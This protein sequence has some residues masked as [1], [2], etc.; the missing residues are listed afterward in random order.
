MG[1]TFLLQLN[2]WNGEEQYQKT[3]W[4]ERPDY[5]GHIYA[6]RR[7]DRIYAL[8]RKLKTVP[9]TPAVTKTEIYAQ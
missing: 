8:M 6:Y 5:Y 7:K 1:Q 4:P 2:R 3:S 9:D